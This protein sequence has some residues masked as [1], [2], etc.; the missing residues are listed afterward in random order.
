MILRKYLEKGA[1]GEKKERGGRGLVISL[2]GN[3]LDLRM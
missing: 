3:L 2:L 1:N